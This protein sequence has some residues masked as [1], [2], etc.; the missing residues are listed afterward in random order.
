MLVVHILH[1]TLR[2][3]QGPVVF[4]RQPPPRLSSTAVYLHPAVDPSTSSGT[5][6]LHLTTDNGKSNHFR[7][8]KRAS[9]YKHQVIAV[10]FVTG[11][12]QGFRYAGEYFAFQAVRRGFFL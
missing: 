12:F 9:A 2:Q 10:C 6:Y 8:C 5:S 3:S 1:W 7:H 4:N 11:V